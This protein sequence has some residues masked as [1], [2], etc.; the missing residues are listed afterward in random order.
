MKRL[1]NTKIN[2]WQE[3]SW[4][5]VMSKVRD[6]QNKIVKATI[7]NYMKLVYKLQN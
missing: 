6:L 1:H 3:I 4:Q 2:N 7:A 5:D